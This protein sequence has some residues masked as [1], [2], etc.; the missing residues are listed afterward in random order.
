VCFGGMYMV[1]NE[2]GTATYLTVP[3]VIKNAFFEKIKRV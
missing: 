3:I 1:E 2:S